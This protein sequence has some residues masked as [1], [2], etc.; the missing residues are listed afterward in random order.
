MECSAK[1]NTN[2]KEI[3]RTFLQLARIPLPC[4]EPGL[5][6]RSSAQARVNGK[7]FTSNTL[8]PHHAVNEAESDIA[9]GSTGIVQRLKPRSRSLIRRTSKKKI[10]DPIS[11]A[12]DCSV[13]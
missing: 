12:D 1:N 10:K 13:S 11:D 3:F 6:R 2:L 5:R 9:S 4:D 7:R 8:S